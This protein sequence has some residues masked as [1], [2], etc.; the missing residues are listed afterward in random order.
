MTGI[1]TGTAAVNVRG[2]VVDLCAILVRDDRTLGSTRIRSQHDTA[3]RNT[4]LFE[5]GRAQDGSRGKGTL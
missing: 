2:N 4:F 5:K 3:L 1:G